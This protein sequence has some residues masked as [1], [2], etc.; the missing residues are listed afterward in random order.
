MKP[1]SR[2]LLVSLLLLSTALVAFA[3]ATI[4]KQSFGKTAAGENVDLYTLKNIH[5]MET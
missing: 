5:G 2:F 4:T 1:L 3:Q